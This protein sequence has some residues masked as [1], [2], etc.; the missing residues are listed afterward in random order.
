MR[1]QKLM[2]DLTIQAADLRAKNTQILNA[3]GA[4]TQQFLNVEAENSVLRAQLAELSHRLD[5][6]N[7]ILGYISA[8]PE[9]MGPAPS[10]GCCVS[11]MPIMASD[12]HDFG[13]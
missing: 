10:L 4:A 11:Q 1:K 13:Y 8:S 6:L 12:Y 3:I 7:E 9:T 5:S 2:G